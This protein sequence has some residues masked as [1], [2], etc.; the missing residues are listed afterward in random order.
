VQA[1]LYEVVDRD[2]FQIMDRH[3]RYDPTDM[4]GSLY[5]RRAVRLLEPKVDAWVYVYSRD[6]ADAPEVAGGDWIKYLATRP[7]S[8]AR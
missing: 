6:I 2:A 3:E 1:E 7:K 4:Q 5:L 8:K